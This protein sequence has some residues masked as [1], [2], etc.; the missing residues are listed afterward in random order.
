MQDSNIFSSSD[1]EDSSIPHEPNINIFPTQIPSTCGLANNSTSCPVF[2]PNEEPFGINPDIIETLNNGSPYDF[3]CLFVD[4]EVLNL[5]VIETNR[6]GNSLY[7]SAQRPKSRLKEW[8]ETDIVEMRTFL[9]IIMWMGLTPHPSIASYWS[10]NDIYKSYISNYMKRN[11]FEL[12][13]RS[14]HCCN[15]NECPRGDRIF[16][17]RGLV[18]MLENKFKNCNIPGEN[19]CV[20]ES[21]IP[22]VGRLSFRQYIQNKR[23]RYG[24]KVFK[25]C[26]NDGYTVGFK[27][28]AGQESVPGMGLSTKIV[29][30]LSEDYLDMGRTIFTDN[31]YTSI[32]LANELLSRSTN[33][34]GTL[35]SNRK[36]NPKNVIDAK[37]KKGEIIS[38]KNENN[39]L[40]LKWKDKRDVLMLST[41][42]ND[43]VIETTNKYG[44]KIVK[45]K[46]VF[47]YNKAKAFVDISDLRGSY[48]SPLRRSLKWYRKVAFDILLNTS[49][50]N[51]LTLFTTVTGNKM[52]VTAFRESILKSLIQK[53]EIS[54][55]SQGENH[56]L[57]TC[58]RGRCYECYNEMVKQG[59]RQHA[60]KV[61]QKVQTMC[62]SC[63][64]P[65]CLDC[66]FT[67][68][69]SKR[70]KF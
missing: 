40:V 15:N 1:E 17:I 14:F 30:E 26:T 25:L 57:V 19:L 16:K 37:L 24:I 67:T 36:F 62:I 6:Y 46:V 12:L 23:H 10:K 70:I 52:G 35:R 51:A 34:V 61:T 63:S 65:L 53:S 38:N 45:P 20:D 9:G 47:D 56:K 59:G 39:I 48:H 64:K 18:D 60:Q 2:N 5:L 54:Q 42:H 49:L 4:D 31:W 50:L 33:S 58:K 27:I 3:F 69:S 8:V 66:F 21:I 41:K 43:N 55:I 29:M 28:Y 11:R 7:A 44:K 68:H 13:L 32:S 22:F